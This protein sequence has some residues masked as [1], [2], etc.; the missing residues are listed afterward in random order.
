M[1]VTPRRSVKVWQT[2]NTQNKTNVKTRV[3]T[4]PEM[5]PYCDTSEVCSGT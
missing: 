2:I 5:N 3:K 4:T 1:L